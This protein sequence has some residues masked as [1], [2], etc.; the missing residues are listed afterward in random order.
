V[1]GG[2]SVKTKFGL[3]A[4]LMLCSATAHAQNQPIFPGPAVSAVIYPAG[5]PLGFEQISLSS[6]SAVGLTV[7]DGATYAMVAAIGLNAIWRDDGTAPSATVGMPI[8]AGRRSRSPISP[9]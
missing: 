9:R 3:L 5:T 8:I 2:I 7:P 1:T 4:A 6:T